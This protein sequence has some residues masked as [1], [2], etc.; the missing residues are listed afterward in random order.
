MRL[1]LHNCFSIS[2]PETLS[3]HPGPPKNVSSITS[4]NSVLS[5]VPASS[6][7][8]NQREGNTVYPNSMKDA[9]NELFSRGVINGEEF[10]QFVRKWVPGS[11]V[12]GYATFMLHSGKKSNNNSS[13]MARNLPALAV[14]LQ[15]LTGSRWTSL[16][17]AFVMCGLQNFDEKVEG[18]LKIVSSMNKIIKRAIR[19]NVPFE[20]K[21]S[22]M[23]LLGLQKNRLCDKASLELL[24]NIASMMRLSNDVPTSRSLANALYALKSMNSTSS[25]VQLMLSCITQSVQSCIERFTGQNLGNALYGLQRMSTDNH[26]VSLLL[27]AL[28]PKVNDCVESLSSQE[29]GNAL[30]GLQGMRSDSREALSMITALVP[31]V[32]K[33][34]DSAS[35]VEV[36]SALFSLRGM[37]SEKSETCQLISALIPMIEGSVERLNFKKVGSVLYCLR[38]L[39]SSTREVCL[40]IAAL[41][42]KVQQC[43]GRFTA[44]TVG[45]ALYGL[46]RMS[47]DNHE[48]SLL[49]SALVPKV[50]DCV[51]S[52]SSQ[53]IG[54]ALYGLQGMGRSESLLRILGVIRHQ[55]S[56]NIDFE[57]LAADELNA[58]GVFVALSMSWLR[59]VSDPEELLEWQRVQELLEDSSREYIPSSGMGS[60]VVPHNSGERRVL[61]AADSLFG[62]SNIQVLNNTLLHQFFECDILLKVPTSALLPGGGTDKGRGDEGEWLTVNIEVDGSQHSRATSIRLDGLRDAYLAE[63]GVVVKRLES[64]SLSLMNEAQLN[65]WILEAASDA[66][67]SCATA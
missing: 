18:Y 2:G 47:T 66:V 17:I 62:S 39:S 36:T 26:E 42:P 51:E 60:R 46:Q 64:R 1:S 22:A 35:S 58:L 25:Q 14:H 12:N 32:Q 15:N 57:S 21:H 34:T 28:V 3:W 65:E 30:Y 49:L 38:C 50:H 52:L 24:S 4:A 67:L 13:N 54:N 20:Y 63:R 59:A 44:H 6:S 53:E 8:T 45:N 5:T 48:V 56:S 29:I 10:D 27:S 40:L 19:F 61:K 37:D 33:C 23:A 9:R 55:A 7:T 41:V 43:E 31:M 16:S 11:S